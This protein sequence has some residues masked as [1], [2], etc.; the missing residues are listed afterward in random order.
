MPISSISIGTSAGASSS[1]TLK[2]ALAEFISMLTFIFAGEGVGMAFGN[3]SFCALSIYFS[4]ARNK[5]T[6]PFAL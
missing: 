6:S 5:E 1:D 3:V 4:M 2:A